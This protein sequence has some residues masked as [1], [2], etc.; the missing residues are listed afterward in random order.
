MRYSIIFNILGM[1]AK[2]IGFL[3]V[4]PIICAILLKENNVIIPFLTTGLMAVLL[5][6]LFSIKK[7]EQ[8]AEICYNT[9]SN[10]SFGGK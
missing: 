7:V 4:I 9:E 1:M 6:F 3:F 5:G 2:Y 8:K 10:Y